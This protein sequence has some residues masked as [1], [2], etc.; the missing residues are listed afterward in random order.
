MAFVVTP[1]GSQKP[2]N[3][4]FLHSYLYPKDIDKQGSKDITLFWIKLGLL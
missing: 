2:Y 3:Y 1:T 4:I